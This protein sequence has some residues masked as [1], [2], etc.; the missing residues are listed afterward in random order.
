MEI[1]IKSSYQDSIDQ[2]NL[3][4]KSGLLGVKIKNEKFVE[5]TT[6][7]YALACM[8]TCFSIFGVKNETIKEK[9]ELLKSKAKNIN[10]FYHKIT[11][12][13][14][15]CPAH[16]KTSFKSIDLWNK[17]L[18]L[19]KDWNGYFQSKLL[20]TAGIDL[21][22]L[23]AEHLYIHFSIPAQVSSLSKGPF[24]CSF[25]NDANL[26]L[27]I[28][29]QQSKIASSKALILWLS[30]HQE[31]I[32]GLI[33]KYG[34]IKFRGFQIDDIK[35]FE[36]IV[37]AALGSKTEDYIGGDGSRD[38]LEGAKNVYTSTKANESYN[39][40]L[41][42]E[43][44]LNPQMPDFISFYCAKAPLP[45]TGQ[46]TLARAEE[47]TERLK[48]K[49]FWEKYVNKNL[50]YILR[51]PPKGHLINKIDPTH[52]T[53][54]QLLGI[55]EK[56]TLSQ[57]REKAEEISKTR[58]FTYQWDGN[59]YVKSQTAPATREHPYKP[60][61]QLWM[62]QIHF[63]KLTPELV[64]NFFLS[65][66]AKLIYLFPRTWRSDVSLEDG[67]SIPD[68]DIKDIFQ[69]LKDHETKCDWQKGDVLL[70]D[71]RT[72]MHGRA[73]SD[74]KKAKRQIYTAISSKK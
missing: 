57:C 5:N 35:A 16:V 41:H 6:Y 32:A 49:S 17:Q 37:E 40:G 70:L 62:N 20:R 21:K 47:I 23:H 11:I 48:Q 51:F 2:L 1:D 29:P 9:I 56:L 10:D 67:T 39:I 12:S 71:N 30:K 13:Q 50:K 55:E 58:E 27:I 44:S 66:M 72:I 25:S 69:T 65:M 68:Q 42:Q 61:E 45:G 46:T 64:G 52:K 53:W 31:I 26:P 14:K 74:A 18:G 54:H 43:R 34:A 36:Q 7:E 60:G 4:M 22:K 63:S 28:S 3:L 59:W 8:S 38:K 24:Y 15:E 33:K 73:P 19:R